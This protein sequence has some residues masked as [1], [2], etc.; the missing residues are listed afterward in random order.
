ML[1]ERYAKNEDI[2]SRIATAIQTEKDMKDFAGF[3][4]DLWEMG[5]IKA[6]E[7]YKAELA[8][9]GYNVKVVPGTQNEVVQT[10]E[11]Q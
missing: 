11:N 7:S 4:A 10:K 5:F 8:K 9:I 6:V 1:K 2:I 3:I